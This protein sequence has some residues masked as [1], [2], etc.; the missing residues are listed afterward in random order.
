[1]D[2]LG[3]AI[4]RNLNSLRLIYIVNHLYHATRFHETH[5]SCEHDKKQ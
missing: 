2:L 5:L 3:M 1:M 4:L